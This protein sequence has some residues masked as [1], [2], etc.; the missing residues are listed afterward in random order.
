M[1]PPSAEG[2]PTG[3]EPVSVTPAVLRAW[4]LPPP[5][6]D[7]ESR[8]RVLV[9]GGGRQTPGAVLLAAESALRTGAGKLQVAT[10]SSLAP[11]VAVALPE[12][13]VV[14]LPE[15]ADGDI[16]PSAAPAILELA[17]G[18]AAVLLG[19]GM[20]DVGAAAKLLAAVA[21]D[22]DTTTVLDAL[23]LAYLT[24]RPEGVRHLGGRVV[25]T[26]NREELAQTLGP[27]GSGV[28]QAPADATVEL[29]RR[30]GAVV[31]SGGPVSWVAGPQEGLWEVET[32]GPGLGVSGSGDVQSGVVLG[33]TAR[34]ATPAQAA[35]WGAYLHG[36]A[37]DRLAAQVGAVGFLARE[38]PA[39]IP[40]VLSEV[41]V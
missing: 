38:L 12:A 1:T 3:R 10:V 30:T 9:V 14:G 20:S 27:E 25:L 2:G 19:P 40:Q 18:C 17:A 39:Q 32:G 23:A 7:K 28:D 36:R 22:L 26:P 37:G 13:S 31:A 35:V 33:L 16:A 6:E 15:T 41:E 24:G 21:P 34:G 29:A 11:H 8:G 5:G 4:P